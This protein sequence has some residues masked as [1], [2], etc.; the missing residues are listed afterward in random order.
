MKILYKY[1]FEYNQIKLT[2]HESK[3]NLCSDL[4]SVGSRRVDVA[5]LR[6]QPLHNDSYTEDRKRHTLELRGFVQTRL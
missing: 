2:M 3:Y 1:F 5:L 6:Q 4:A